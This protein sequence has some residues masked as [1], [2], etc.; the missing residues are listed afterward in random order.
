[1]TNTPGAATKCLRIFCAIPDKRPEQFVNHVKSEQ[2][3]VSSGQTIVQVATVDF[4]I[5]TD[6]SSGMVI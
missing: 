1:M 4:V 2:G 6:D 5:I 3:L